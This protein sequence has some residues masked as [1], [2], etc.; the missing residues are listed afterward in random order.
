MMVRL[1]VKDA[2]EFAKWLLTDFEDNNETVMVAPG[3]GFYGSALGKNEIRIA[4]VLNQ[5][6][7]KRCLQLI[8]LALQKYIPQ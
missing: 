3:D 7:L 1:R 4:Y 6:S 2:G 8:A 5:T